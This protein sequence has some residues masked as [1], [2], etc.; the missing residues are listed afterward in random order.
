MN[1][2]D[3]RHS[4]PLFRILLVE[5]DRHLNEDLKALIERRLPGT[6]VDT[7]ETIEDALE[8]LFRQID[9]SLAILDIRLPVR[10]GMHP[11]AD[12]ELP[13]RLKI[14]GIASICITGFRDSADVEAYLE[15]RRLLDP[16]LKVISKRLG[17][18]VDS[19]LNEIRGWLQKQACLKVRNALVDVFEQTSRTAGMGSG[20]AEL[21]SL[22]QTIGDYWPWLDAETRDQVR[23]RFDVQED[24]ETIT[25]MSLFARERDA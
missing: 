1:A 21:M 9:Y 20:T 2:F 25:R 11:E 22:Q 16:P 7:A 18:F 15:R 24:S 5:D 23:A 17:E 8:F 14:K 13:S 10:R 4:A 12:F 19:I 6:A 3:T